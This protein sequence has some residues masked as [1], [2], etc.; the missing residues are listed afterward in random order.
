[1]DQGRG[2][3]RID[4]G[5][6][7]GEDDVAAR[8]VS[9]VVAAKERSGRHVDGPVQFGLDHGEPLF[10]ARPGG[11]LEG[12]RWRRVELEL[13]LLA[14]LADPAAQQGMPGLRGVERRAKRIGGDVPRQPDDGDE[15]ER[16]Q[17]IDH[18]QGALE[19]LDGPTAA[20]R[21]HCRRSAAS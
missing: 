4:D 3:P 14:D 18:A 11:G 1:V 16:A 10:A 15:V 7:P 19:T 21:G 17:R 13:L 9:Q 5:V 2:G 20:S 6:V 12:N 8:G